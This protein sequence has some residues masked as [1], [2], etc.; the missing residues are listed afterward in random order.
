MIRVEVE[1]FQSIAHVKFEIDGFTAIVGDSDLGK[2]ALV[3]AIRSALMGAP[4]TDF[5][6]H[7]A[8]CE[9][10]LKNNKKCRCQAT[11]QIETSLYHFK[12]EKGDSINKYT[13]TRP[14]M[15]PESFSSVDRGTPDFLLPEFTPI[16]IDGAGTLI[17][18]AD[19]FRVSGVG[20]PIFLLDVQ[21]SAVAEV[22]SDVARLDSLN[23]A[24]KMVQKDRK[25][26]SATR[27]V[28]EQD[29]VRL[30]GELQAFDGLDGV[31]TQVHAA[32]AKEAEVDEAQQK[33]QVV[34]DF[35]RTAEVLSGAIRTLTVCLKPVVPAFAPIQDAHQKLE[36]LD[37]LWAEVVARTPDIRRLTGVDKVQMP[38]AISTDDFEALRKV[39]GWWSRYD[40]LTAHVANEAADLEIPDRSSLAQDFERFRTLH[41]LSERHPCVL[42]EVG[43]L[44][45]QLAAAEAEE[46]EAIKELRAIGTC[47]T[48]THTLGPE[49]HIHLEGLT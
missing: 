14:G 7:G 1:N 12:W 11:V 36:N 3:R 28:R 9:R 16:K 19:Q 39:D 41:Q 27:N 38:A 8:A 2:S 4:G 32:E 18:V 5:V 42:A 15:P 40:Q 35:I 22:L 13:V 49:D 25:E 21:G 26:A 33:C 10:L 20:G 34:R 48:C 31:V 47:P 17:Q 29:A 23:E 37:R 46:A 45:A 30:R 44:A 43:E 6:R 24:M